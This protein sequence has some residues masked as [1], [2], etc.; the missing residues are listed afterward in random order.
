MCNAGVMHKLLE[1]YD[2]L[3]QNTHH[4]SWLLL[5][6]SIMLTNCTASV[7]VASSNAK[8]FYIL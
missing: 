8:I 6:V 2:T 5:L 1:S 4:I 7:C 3:Y